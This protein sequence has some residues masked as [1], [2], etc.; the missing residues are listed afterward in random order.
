M[1][2]IFFCSNIH[3][4]I[5]V[6]SDCIETGVNYW[7][8]PLISDGKP[9]NMYGI[10]DNAAECQGKCQSTNGCKWFN[11]DDS[12]QCWLL[13][14]RDIKRPYPMQDGASGPRSCS[15]TE[16]EPISNFSISILFNINLG[17]NYM[18][19]F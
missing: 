2:V 19:K 13:K 8:D 16:W 5:L 6:D 14:K 3:T 12:G 1:K 15:G 7:G 17:K 9:Y 18:K 4:V 10:T 11:W